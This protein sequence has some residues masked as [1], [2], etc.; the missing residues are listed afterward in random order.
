[1]VV[2]TMNREVNFAYINHPVFLSWVIT[3]FRSIRVRGLLMNGL[4]MQSGLSESRPA[5]QPASQPARWGTRGHDVT[6][7]G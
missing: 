6:L 5:T 4:V 3:H 2:C 7:V 1:M